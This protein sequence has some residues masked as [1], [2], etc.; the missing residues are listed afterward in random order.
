MSSQRQTIM[1]FQPKIKKIW[2]HG[3]FF[4]LILG[5]LGFSV[6]YFTITIPSAPEL[7]TGLPV[8]LSQPEQVAP[9][10]PETTPAVPENSAS[11]LET[12]LDHVFGG[13]KEA[14]QKKDLALLLSLYS[15]DYP[16]LTKKVASIKKSW[17]LFDYH[18]MAFKV[19][20]IKQLAENT[21]LAQVTWDVLV[22]NLQTQKFKHTSRT[23]QVTLV[24]ESDHWRIV[25]L[26]N[27][28]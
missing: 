7:S 6:Y 21:M 23:Y 25:G 2:A 13:I 16:Q 9:V 1:I 26:K 19:L 18:D 4:G 27:A 8:P 11:N 22:K 10:V 12:E 20:E 24:K 3:F 5:V 14:N 15:P 28:P 17:R